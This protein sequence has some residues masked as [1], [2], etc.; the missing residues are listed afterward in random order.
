MRTV[1]FAIMLGLIVAAVAAAQSPD[2]ERL[3][4]QNC[5]RCHEGDLPA[6]FSSSPI[7]EYP[8]ARIYEALSAGI[9]AGQATGLSKEDKRAV[10]E[11]VSGAAPGSLPTPL[12]QIPQTAYCSSGGAAPADP[13]AGPSW[14]GWSPDRN[15][16]RFQSA[17]AAGLG[18]NSVPDLSLKWAF[19]F[20]GVTV[21]S[22]QATIVGGRALVGSSVGV[23][24]ALD[25]DT[26]CVHWAHETDA[27]VRSTIIVGPGPDDRA[28]AFFGDM[29]GNAYAVDFETGERRWRVEV[30]DHRQARITGAP[31]LH[32]GRLYVPVASL[33]ELAAEAPTY[34][35][36]TF[37]G[38]VAALDATTG[39]RLWQ[40]YPI[41]E[42]PTRTGL[43]PAGVQ[44]WGPSGVGIWASPTIDPGRN[45]MYVATGDSYSNPVS[46]LSDAI[47]AL[48][49]DTGDVLWVSQTTPGDAWVAACLSPDEATRANCPEDA[50]PD[51]DF[52]SA[53]VLATVGGREL[54]LAGQKSGVMYGL[55]PGTGEIVWETRVSGGGILGGIEWG[56]ASD[57]ETVFASISDALEK[58]PGDAGGMVAL[59]IATGDV[60]WEAPPFQDT[61]GNRPGCH[62]AQPGAVTAIPG[63]VFSG[64]LDGH[65]RAYSSDTGAVIWDVDTA[66][67]YKT[68]NGVPGRGGSLN[69]PGATI[70]GG[71]LYVSSGYGLFNYM[72][73]NVLLAFSVDG[74]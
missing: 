28:T 71:M 73:G 48:A 14:N 65:I 64:S 61:C 67:E 52:G 23:V 63:V 21:A 42:E 22:L 68:V 69:G 38:S 46:P 47:V 32:D 7:R 55:D 19:G 66:G 6:L 58:A 49:L 41:D 12:D 74:Q 45:R 44:Q 30:D 51:H 62:T 25:A 60:L 2:G 5:G 10:A 11:Y 24:Y 72:P 39:R 27:G 31:A 59:R 17:E 54:L 70:A 8:A 3:Y 20:P 40:R 56:F 34:Q 15:N 36:C 35:C 37:R 9:M 26:G 57:G 16:A 50:G 29:T 18:A 4:R 13:Y 43:N 1:C 53:I 33:E